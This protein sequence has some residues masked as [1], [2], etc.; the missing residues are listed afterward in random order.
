VCK[1]DKFVNYTTLDV[2]ELGSAYE[3]KKVWRVSQRNGEVPVINGHV[4]PQCEHVGRVKKLVYG[5]RDEVQAVLAA[6]G[7]STQCLDVLLVCSVAEQMVKRLFVRL[8][9][10]VEDTA[11]IL[12][13]IRRERTV[14]VGG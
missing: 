9:S 8:V 14:G 4:F 7:T 12:V 1:I 2:F 5:L 11:P 6:S 13:E 10:H 3:N